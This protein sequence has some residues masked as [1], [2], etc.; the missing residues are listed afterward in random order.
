M[1]KRRS[2]SRDTRTYDYAVFQTLAYEFTR[3]DTKETERKIKGLLRRHDLGA[4]DQARIDLFRNLKNELQ[5]EVGLMQRSRYYIGS[6][7][8]FAAL[9]DFDSQKMVEELTSAYS[10][11]S[12]SDMI[13]IVGFALYLYY[14][15]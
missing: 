13:G 5:A 11:V 2:S 6:T 10:S 8:E 14:L 3:D 15:R 7:S 1:G 4:Y 12:P 9:E